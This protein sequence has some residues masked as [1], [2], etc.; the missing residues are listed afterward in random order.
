MILFFR[1]NPTVLK[2]NSEVLKNQPRTWHSGMSPGRYELVALPTKVFKCHGCSQ[3]FADKYPS[4]P[5]YIVVKHVDRRIPGRDAGGK[6]VYNQDF[7]N[8]YYHLSKDHIEKKNPVFDGNVFVTHDLLSGVVNINAKKRFS[9]V[10]CSIFHAVV[11]YIKCFVPLNWVY[12][13]VLLCCKRAKIDQ[14]DKNEQ[15]QSKNFRCQE[16]SGDL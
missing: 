7:T 10:C 14:M 11:I 1:N 4:S 12:W 5:Y 13:A 9:A 8:T 2:N 3:N 15:L 16:I 6:I